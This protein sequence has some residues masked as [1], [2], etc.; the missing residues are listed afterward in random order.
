[1]IC[2]I[3]IHDWLSLLFVIWG[4]R[5]FVIVMPLIASRI[6]ISNHLSCVRESFV[7]CSNALTFLL[8]A[9]YFHMKNPKWKNHCGWFLFVRLHSSWT[10]DMQSFTL[11]CDHRRC[12]DETRNK[13]QKHEQRIASISR[14]VWPEDITRLILCSLLND[15]FSLCKRDSAPC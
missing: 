10:S 5:I 3:I 13:P 1:M 14:S 7:P 8:S 11:Q 2:V 12:F 4:L 15:P 6:I 9:I